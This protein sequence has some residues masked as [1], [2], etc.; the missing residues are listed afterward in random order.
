MEKEYN[1]PPYYGPQPTQTGVYNPGPQAAYPP[2]TGPHA[3]PYQP[4]QYGFGAPPTNVQ[5][6]MVPVVTQ[7]AVMSLTDVPSRII[8]PH[9]MTEVLTEIEYLNGLLTWLIC[10]VLALF[11]SLIMELELDPPPYPGQ[12]LDEFIIPYPMQPVV[13]LPQPVGTH[14]MP[15]SPVTQTAPTPAASVEKDVPMSP[16]TQTATAPAASVEKDV[17]MSPVT[18]TATAPAASVEKDV[19]MSPVTQTATAP[20][21]QPPQDVSVSQP[22]KKKQPKKVSSTGLFGL[23]VDGFA[24]ASAASS[25]QRSMQTEQPMKPSSLT[26]QSKPEPQQRS[27]LLSATPFLSARVPVQR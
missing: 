21:V 24:E 1:P 25:S 5:P 17:P 11:V 26:A 8:C 2:Q 20:V 7:P 10:G 27:R 23:M 3:A 18:Q 15:M 6:M 9:C 12:P 16:V 14:G 19:P 4:P 13:N 22:V